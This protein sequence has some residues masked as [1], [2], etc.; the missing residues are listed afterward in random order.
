MRLELIRLKAG[1]Q[2][3]Q[4]I[5]SLAM[6]AVHLADSVDGALY[7]EEDLRRGRAPVGGNGGRRG[8]GGTGARS[9]LG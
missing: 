3:H 2:T 5:T 4:T 9:S 8:A 7:V 6:Q 1:T